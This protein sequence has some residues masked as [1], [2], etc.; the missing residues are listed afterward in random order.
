MGLFVKL[1][2]GPA[3]SC[4]AFTWSP[5]ARNSPGFNSLGDKDLG[6][7]GSSHSP[8]TEKLPIRR[9]VVQDG[10]IK[11]AAL[12]SAGK[13]QLEQCIHSAIMFSL[14]LCTK[15]IVSLDYLT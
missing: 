8:L 5:R 7:A 15:C 11:R 3:P 14:P 6:T 12:P 2:W 13:S 9:K 4:V 1:M 10:G